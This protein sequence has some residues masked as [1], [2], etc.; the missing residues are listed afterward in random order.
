VEE[1]GEQNNTISI[2]FVKFGLIYII[3]CFP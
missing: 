3:F 1:K 2:L